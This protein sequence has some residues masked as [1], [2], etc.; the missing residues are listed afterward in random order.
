MLDQRPIHC[1]WWTILIPYFVELELE[2]KKFD[3]TMENDDIMLRQAKQGMQF[4]VEMMKK[5]HE[6]FRG[7]T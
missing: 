4:I 2:K 1:W 6:N 3:A 7:N 5:K